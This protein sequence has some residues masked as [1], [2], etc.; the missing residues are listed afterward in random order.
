MSKYVVKKVRTGGAKSP[1]IR[2]SR[3]KP[4]VVGGYYDSIMSTDGIDRYGGLPYDLRVW[5]NRLFHVP[6]DSIY[7]GSCDEQCS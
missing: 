3:L 4:G 6:Q 2:R 7:G 5:A 1:A